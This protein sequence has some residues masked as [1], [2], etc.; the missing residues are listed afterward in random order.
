M[1]L[2]F[3]SWLNGLDVLLLLLYK[4]SLYDV[5]CLRLNKF[6]AEGESLA[7]GVVYR[8]RDM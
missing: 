2:E 1:I 6:S 8:I 5:V 3:V 7:S 4:L